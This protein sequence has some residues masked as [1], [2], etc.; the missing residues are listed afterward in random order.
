MTLIVTRKTY[1]LG[2]D[3][4]SV[5]YS[6]ITSSSHFVSQL[7][8]NMTANILKC[9]QPAAES[10]DNHGRSPSEHGIS[11]HCVLLSHKPN[12]HTT[13]HLST[14]RVTISQA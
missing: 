7:Q 13:W 2:R 1:G 11:P 8:Y 14:L 5:F 10:R 9:A 6:F 3:L 12:M 4:E